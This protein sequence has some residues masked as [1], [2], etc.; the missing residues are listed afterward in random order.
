ME[1]IESIAGRWEAVPVS[2]HGFSFRRPRDD[3]FGDALASLDSIYKVTNQIDNR[4]VLTRELVQ[5]V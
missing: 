2:T 3:G 1:A 5:N 4:W